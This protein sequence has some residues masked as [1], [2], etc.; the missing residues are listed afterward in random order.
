MQRPRFLREGGYDDVRSA[1]RSVACLIE[2]D[3]SRLRT[4]GNMDEMV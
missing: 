3:E 4:T 1:E 2:T